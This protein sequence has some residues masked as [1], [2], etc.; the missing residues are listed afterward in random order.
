[1]GQRRVR[2]GEMKVDTAQNVSVTAGT[3]ASINGAN[4]EKGK[5]SLERVILDPDAGANP[6]MAIQVLGGG[7]INL[8]AHGSATQASQTPIVSLVVTPEGGSATVLTSKTLATGGGDFIL[9]ETYEASPGVQCRCELMVDS[10]GSGT[11]AVGIG[12]RF[13]AEAYD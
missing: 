9:E 11:V 8:R 7:M 3:R 4:V 13:K 2:H 12:S 6:D 10:N 5:V 1:M